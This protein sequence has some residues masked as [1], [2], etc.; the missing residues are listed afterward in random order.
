[1]EVEVEVTDVRFQ[2]TKEG[3]E[4][5]GGVEL[6]AFCLVLDDRFNEGKDVGVF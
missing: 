4:S 6:V 2:V 1:M 5:F 3:S